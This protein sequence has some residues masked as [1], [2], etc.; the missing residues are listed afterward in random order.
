MKRQLLFFC[1]IG[2]ISAKLLLVSCAKEKVPVPVVVDF[3][4]ADCP[5]TIF[6]STQIKP[7][8]DIN[9]ATSNCHSTAVHQ[10]GY[11][12]TNHENVSTNVDIIMQSMDPNSGLSLMPQGMPV[13][14][15]S[16]IKMFNCWKNQGKLNN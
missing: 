2:V 14:A 3:L 1:F 13:V 7:F 5:D 12:L 4:T 11:D 15:D 8:V 16:V 9:C 10:G 6:Y